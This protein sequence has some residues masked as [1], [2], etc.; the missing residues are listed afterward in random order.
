[1][2][3]TGTAG[4]REALLLKGFAFIYNFDVFY[5]T[6]ISAMIEPLCVN[7]KHQAS[8]HQRSTLNPVEALLAYVMIYTV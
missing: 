5:A 6:F 4:I 2:I 7:Q 3:I 8:R 1:M